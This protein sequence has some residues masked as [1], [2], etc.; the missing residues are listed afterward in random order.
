VILVGG[1]LISTHLVLGVLTLDELSAIR[2]PQRHRFID[3][4]ATGKRWSVHAIC[5]RLRS[6]ELRRRTLDAADELVTRLVAGF[7]PRLKERSVTLDGNRLTWQRTGGPKSTMIAIGP[8]EFSFNEDPT[9]RI[10]FTVAGNA[11]TA[12]QLVRGDG[13][14]VDA[15]RTR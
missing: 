14:K 3:G 6:D 2:I 4:I 5:S 11:V 1:T 8:N 7:E 10:R 13:S 9:S 12:V 15:E